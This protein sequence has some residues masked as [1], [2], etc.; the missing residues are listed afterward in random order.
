[1]GPRVGVGTLEKRSISLSLAGVEQRFLGWP[2]H[3]LVTVPAEL[4]WEFKKCIQRIYFFLVSS[5]EGKTTDYEAR[6]PIFFFS[7]ALRPNAGHDLLI[8]EVS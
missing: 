6:Y 5:D 3:N 7:L 2:A 4:N 1:M 8:F